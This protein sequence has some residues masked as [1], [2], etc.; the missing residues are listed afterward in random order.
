MTQ[1]VP[2][3]VSGGEFLDGDTGELVPWQAASAQHGIVELS[4]NVVATPT[5]LI[6]THIT[7]DEWLDLF[8]KCQSI[9]EASNWWLGDLMCAIPSED[10]TQALEEGSKAR[11]CEWVSRCVQPA[12]RRE[13][14]SWS[15]HRQVAKLAPDLQDDLLEVAESEGF[16]VA[17]F[18]AYL[19]A[20]DNA[21]KGKEPTEPNITPPIDKQAALA[22]SEARIGLQWT[23]A[24]HNS[25]VFYLP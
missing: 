12:E 24:D 14:L 18:V 23:R 2:L 16:T 5:S 10:C 22:L 3:H 8:D 11:I 15:H 13:G 25:L 4:P 20:F 9:H 17:Q 7:R 1:T 21:S 19:K 6:V